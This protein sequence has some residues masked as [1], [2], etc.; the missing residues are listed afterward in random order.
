MALQ[1]VLSRGERAESGC[2]RVGLS[3]HACLLDRGMK[4]EGL[5]TTCQR[6]PS[7]QGG[8]S[9]IGSGRPGQ[10]LTAFFWEMHLSGHWKGEAG[11]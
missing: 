5:T 4:W 10:C 8:K 1:G 7:S 2:L 6:L 11:G 9:S 3:W